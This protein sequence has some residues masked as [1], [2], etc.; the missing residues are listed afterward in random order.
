[1]ERVYNMMDKSR[2]LKDIED[3]NAELDDDHIV[4]EEVIN[5]KEDLDSKIMYKNGFQIQMSLLQE[6]N[7]TKQ[8][9]RRYF[10]KN[11]L[12]EDEENL[13]WKQM[14]AENEFEGKKNGDGCEDLE[15]T[16]DSNE[17]FNNE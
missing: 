3:N 7:D 9:E 13:E 1:M 17:G 15:E 8:M 4:K 11:Q 5:L 16:I 14:E 10:G 6:R 2:S 12:M